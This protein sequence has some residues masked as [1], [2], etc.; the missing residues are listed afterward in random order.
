MASPDQEALN[1][2][3]GVVG[4]PSGPMPYLAYPAT[5]DYPRLVYSAP[6]FE[7]VAIADIIE[8]SVMEA[9]QGMLPTLVPPYVTAAANAAVQSLAVQLVGSAMSGP[10]LLSP[11]NPT[12]PTMAATKQYVDTMV[13]TVVPEVPPV[14]AGGTWA[15]QTGQWVPL[16]GGGSVT[17]IATGV[18]LTGGPITTSGTIAMANMA[19]NSIKGNNTGAVA[20]PVD[21]N[22]GQVMAMLGAAPLNSPVFTGTP[23]LPA[24]ATGVTQP[25]TDND[26]SLATTAFAFPRAGGQINPGGVLVGTAG[27]VPGTGALTLNANTVVPANPAGS[28]LL[29]VIA[30]DNASNITTFDTYGTSATSGLFLRHARGTAASPAAIQS[31]DYFAVIAATGYA[32]TSGYSPFGTHCL[33]YHATENWTNTAQGSALEVITVAAGTTTPVASLSLQGNAATFSGSVTLPSGYSLFLNGATSG[34]PGLIVSDSNNIV[35]RAAS[36]SGGHLFQ[37]SIGSVNQ[38]ITDSTGNLTINGATATKASGTT[39]ANPSSRDIKQDIQPY[40]GNLGDLLDLNPVTYRFTADSGFLTTETHI[41]LVHDE[42][43]HM[44]ELHRTLTIGSGED[45][46]EVDGLDCSAITFCLINAVKELS[47]RLTALEGRA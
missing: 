6:R 25:S 12:A 35:Y 31:G 36:A 18:G 38:M 27:A 16:A 8:P 40:T 47:A 4:T 22:V 44:P 7:I 23:V 32:G 29:W 9:V 43:V 1:A 14:P 46:R 41:G 37:N 19:A 21:L 2:P 26:T 3:P 34:T 15:R 30:A 39:W 20:S 45:A 42:T 24:G 28:D 11:P 33:R 5:A 10:L 17:N 13:A